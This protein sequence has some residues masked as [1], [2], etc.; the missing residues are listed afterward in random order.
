MALLLECS[1]PGPGDISLLMPAVFGEV[2]LR[3][4]TRDAQYVAIVFLFFGGSP[5]VIGTSGL[6]KP[7]IVKFCGRCLS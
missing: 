1:V 7:V 5:S 6:F 3:V 2:L 4:F